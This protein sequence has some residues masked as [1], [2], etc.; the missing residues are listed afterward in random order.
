MLFFR[1]ADVATKVASISSLMPVG[2]N[3][4]MIDA[5][6]RNS[7][8]SAPELSAIEPAVQDRV[9]GASRRRSVETETA[10]LSVLELF[11]GFTK[12]HAATV[13][14]LP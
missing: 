2:R 3:K 14:R 4:D 11:E 12:Q 13:E 8:R 9:S 5:R 1:N 10:A 6:G 7:E